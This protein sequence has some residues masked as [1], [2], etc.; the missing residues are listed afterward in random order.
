MS[1]RDPLLIQRDQR[2]QHLCFFPT[3]RHQHPHARLRNHRPQ[4]IIITRRRTHTKPH[5][6]HRPKLPRLVERARHRQPLLNASPNPP[7]S[8]RNAARKPRRRHHR[9]LPRR[10]PRNNANRPLRSLDLPI[11]PD[12]SRK[13]RRSAD[14]HRTPTATVQIRAGILR[15]QSYRRVL[16]R[17]L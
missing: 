4:P 14:G 6:P 3:K 10:N 15:P 7:Y 12:R 11:P 13:P 17:V 8:R 16:W 5:L 1:R 2:R 9:L